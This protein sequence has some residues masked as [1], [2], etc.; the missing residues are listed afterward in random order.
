MTKLL[1]KEGLN[2]NCD[3][4]LPLHVHSKLDG[5]QF[6]LNGHYNILKEYIEYGAD[7]DAAYHKY[8]WTALMMA[9]GAEQWYRDTV[10]FAKNVKAV[11]LL[12]NAGANKDLKCKKGMTA[13][14]YALFMCNP[15]NDKYTYNCVKRKDIEGAIETYT[16]II[17][18][19]S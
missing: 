9:A 10:N 19:L 15:T 2:P 16:Q 6:E 11:E 8:G 5:D 7:L 17:K 14:D 12:L 13:L 3:G 18:L 4:M 1:L